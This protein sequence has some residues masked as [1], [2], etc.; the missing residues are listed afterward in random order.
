M[1]REYGTSIEL[2]LMGLDCPFTADVEFVHHPAIRGGYYQPDE[3]AWIE[4]TKVQIFEAI[5]TPDGKHRYE[6]REC[7]AWLAEWIASHDHTIEECQ[8]AI[9]S[10]WDERADYLRDRM[11]DREMLA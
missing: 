9:G 7:P 8:A 2:D 1:S 11:L 10:E 4:V 6:E 3:A 5:P